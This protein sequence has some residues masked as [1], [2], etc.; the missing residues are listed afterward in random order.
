MASRGNHLKTVSSW[1]ANLNRLDLKVGLPSAALQK[2]LSRYRVPQNSRDEKIPESPRET[3]MTSR[4]STPM[5][6]L[7]DFADSVRT[8]DNPVAASNDA[9]P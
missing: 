7:S 2:I 3:F 6:D 4:G 8:S 1:N 5:K 9:S